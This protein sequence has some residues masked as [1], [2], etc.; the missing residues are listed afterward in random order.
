MGIVP[1][2]GLGATHNNLTQPLGSK[3]LPMTLVFADHYDDTLTGD[4]N[5]KALFDTGLH[6][7][8]ATGSGTTIN[9]A[10][11]PSVIMAD[12]GSTTLDFPHRDDMTHQWAPRMAGMTTNITPPSLNH[13]SGALEFGQIVQDIS[14]SYHDADEVRSSV[15]FA[16]LSLSEVGRFTAYERRRYNSG[17]PANHTWQETKTTDSDVVGSIDLSFGSF[18]AS[19]TFNSEF[20]SF[21]GGGRVEAITHYSSADLPSNGLGAAWGDAHNATFLT[22]LGSAPISTQVNDTE[23][24]LAIQSDDVSFSTHWSLNL[25]V[26]QPILAS[27]TT[28]SSPDG[29]PV[30]VSISEDKDSEDLLFG[31]ETIQSVLVSDKFSDGTAASSAQEPMTLGRVDLGNH[32]VADSCGLVGYEGVITATAFFSITKDTDPDQT[33]GAVSDTGDTSKHY[34]GLNIQVHSGTTFRR[35]GDPDNGGG[36]GLTPLAP[37]RYGSDGASVD[38]M[39]D[40]LK[41]S[42]HREGFSTTID[43]NNTTFHTRR[44]VHYHTDSNANIPITGGDAIEVGVDSGI[45]RESAAVADRLFGDTAKAGDSWAGA[46]T[47]SSGWLSESIPTKVRIVPQ[48]RGYTNVQVSAGSSKLTAHPSATD[49]T[50]R[51]PI[52]DYH[53]LVSVADPADLTFKADTGSSN[54]VIGDPT[55]RNDPD[56]NRLHADMD[57]SDL[58]CTIYHGIVRINPDTL[59]QIYLDPTDL[60]TGYD[61]IGAGAP[62][63]VLPRHSQVGDDG[64]ASMGWGLHQITPF[65]PLASRQW[66]RVPKLCAAI[67]SGGFYQRGGVSH[68]WDAD[69][70]GGELFVGADIID[71]TDFA[72]ETTKDGKPYFGIW[73]HG[74]ITTNGSHEPAMPQGCE[75]MIFRYSPNL[76]PYHPASKNTTASDNPLRTALGNNASALDGANAYSAQYKTGYTITDE[77]LLADSAWAVHDWVFPQVELMRYLGLEKKSSMRH[78]KHS[79]SDGSEVI[80]HPTVHCSS[81]RIMDDG[82]MMMAMVHRDYIDDVNEF[83]AADIGYPANPDLSIASCPTGYVYSNGQCVPIVSGGTADGD[84]IFDP[85]TGDTYAN[86]DGHPKPEQSGT[87]TQPSGDNFSQ[88][89]TWNKLISSTSA[90]SLIL[91]FSDAPANANGQVARGRADFSLKWELVPVGDEQT[92]ELA[93]QSWTNEDTWWSGA[94]IS[95]WYDESGQ[96]AIPIT[97]GSYPECRMSH[98]TLPHSMPWLD[99]DLKIH[100]GLPFR[101]P[102]TMTAAH[103]SLGNDPMARLAVVDAWYRSRY[104][105]LKFTRFV[106]TTIGFADFGAG[107]NP[108]QELG[109]SGWSFP[110]GL[111]DPIGYGDGTDFFRDSTTQANWKNMGDEQDYAETGGDYQPYGAVVWDLADITFPNDLISLKA[112]VAGVET[113]L[114]SAPIRATS[115]ANLHSLLLSD[116]GAAL[117]QTEIEAHC[118]P[119][120][121]ALLRDG[122]KIVRRFDDTKDFPLPQPIIQ[123][124][125]LRQ[126]NLRFDMEF[127]DNSSASPTIVWSNIGRNT[128]RGAMSSWSYHG[129]LHYGLSATH[130]PYRVDRVFKQVHAGLGYD[131]PLHLLIPPSVHVRA[132]A[133]GNGQIDLEMETPFHRTDYQ[134]LIGASLFESGF[135]LGGASPAGTDQNPLGQWYLRSN[136]WDSPVS[137]GGA[138]VSGISLFNQRIKGA[139]ISGSVGLEAYWSDHPTD[140]FHAGAMPILPNNDYD[141]AMI[142]SNRYAPVMLARASEMHDLDVLATS[143]QLLSSVDVHVSQ[144]ARPFWDSGSIVSAQALGEWDNMVAPYFQEGTYNRAQKEATDAEFPPDTEAPL[145][146]YVQARA[147]QAL[148]MGKGQRIIRTPEGTLHHFVIKRSLQSGASNQPV[149]THMKK[150]LGSD[151][152]WSRRAMRNSPASQTNNGEDECGKI[153]TTVSEETGYRD[154]HKVCGAAYASDS[155]GTIHAVIEYHAN[156]NNQTEQR[157]HLLVYH[158]ADRVMTTSSPEPVYDWDWSV[159]DPVVINTYVDSNPNTVAGSLHDLR[160]PS[161]VCD[162]KDRLHLVVNR[163]YLSTESSFSMD[164]SVILYAVKEVEDANFPAPTFDSD[165]NGIG[166]WQTVGTPLTDPS[167][168]D[169]NDPDNS[170]HLTTWACWPKVCLRSDDIPVVFWLGQ[171][172]F[173]TDSDNREYDAVY[174]NIG[175]VGTGGRIE[176]NSD[177]PCHVLGLEP[178]SRISFPTT[179]AHKR[180]N[181]Y[182]AIIDDKDMAVVVGIRD[183]RRTVSSK[184]FANR[185]TLINRFNTR[186]T[187]AEQYTTTDG[188]GDTRTLFFAPTY[189]G[190]TEMRYVDT[191]LENPTLTIN[192]KGEYHLVIGFTMTGEDDNRMGAT[193][194]DQD[195]A[196]ESAVHPL[197]WA[198]TPLTGSGNT[199]YTGG[200][201]SVSGS[202]DWTG[203]VNTGR[204]PTY[205]NGT[206]NSHRHLMHIWF[207]S[208]E[209]DEDVSADDRVIRSVNMRWMSVPSLRFDSTKGWQP[210][211]SAQTLAG[212]EDFPHMA[213]QI[214]YQRFW[215]YDASEIDLSWRTNELSWYR[216]PHHGSSLY[217]PNLGGV[218]MTPTS[219]LGAGL[220]LQGFPSGE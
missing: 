72:V 29:L 39:T 14:R 15:P 125:G 138:L 82:R 67:E 54:T 143:E 59:E 152:F 180:I 181:H 26:R 140:H 211:G 9:R 49:I 32:V 213:G 45:R 172:Q 51:K 55:S 116:I 183:D 124:A 21:N 78:P 184:T 76:D 20:P 110:T 204:N 1:T 98:A 70:Y 145:Q 107:A 173:T 165:G 219:G 8:K 113:E 28:I 64:K 170:H 210:I 6:Q 155:K 88:Y 122:D 156:P 154:R 123:D 102:A 13:E 92:Q 118:V 100:H 199:L 115:V 94:R 168:N 81:L 198:G 175:S 46:Q 96:R 148:G 97:Y 147:G 68:L 44:N 129:A 216:T 30:S 36:Y 163:P 188:L 208:Y 114:I 167:D 17:R 105:F 171:A 133:G 193:F 194:R 201:A 43:A 4:L 62:M 134:H 60:P 104:D 182:D 47:L 117:Y 218:N 190:S 19:G 169:L 80:L 207:P 212:N 186:K 53:I 174:A 75:L 153:F 31:A 200:Y 120:G 131:L 121:G 220:G 137:K 162:S 5:R 90:R 185:H 157:A 93:I 37:F 103:P 164:T 40:A 74:Q 84:D 189:D 159:H 177:K 176:F 205:T 195:L 61:P 33:Q 132:R 109:W 150:P 206:T 139:V 144:T 56:S 217:L 58:P 191:F 112:V 25:G 158:K 166:L 24:G 7:T 128:M 83:P 27:G 149:W 73:K 192:G 35:N 214:R 187:F 79:E 87:E 66:V 12:R 196:L 108:H 3:G 142:E 86:A 202:P 71:A 89:P 50:F 203:R 178:N 77:R 22:T 48:V 215:G 52:V 95:Y 65:R 69:A 111:F 10:I 11:A 119:H 179:H 42:A 34:A 18:M 101:Q 38:V 135:E 91:A 41:T 23:T 2:G 63:S 85:Q 99:T 209:Y 57:L 197:Q 161:L 130:H 106:P 151:L 126:I 16:R 146:P 136:L 160:M 127:A 141:L